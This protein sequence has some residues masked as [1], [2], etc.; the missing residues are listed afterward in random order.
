MPTANT[1]AMNAKL[2]LRMDDMLVAEAKTH[3][4]R[5]GK[6]V[7]KMFGEF[8]TSLGTSQHGSD[9]PPVTES[10]LGIMKGN[11]VAEPDYKEHLREKYS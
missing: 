3:A 5:R 6:S 8:L 4:A 7:S 9:L 10:L 1:R 2:T 11:R